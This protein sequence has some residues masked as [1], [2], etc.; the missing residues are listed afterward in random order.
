MQTLF[1]HFK[2]YEI[3]MLIVNKLN[4]NKSNNFTTFI[5]T[6]KLSP[7]TNTQNSLRA[8]YGT[9]RETPTPRYRALAPQF[10]TAAE[11]TMAWCSFHHAAEVLLQP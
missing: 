4:K 1:L 5:V 8:A 2:H 11:K 9:H 6:T 7:E 10:P 3:D